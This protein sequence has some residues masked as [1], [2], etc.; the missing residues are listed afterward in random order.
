VGA[1]SSRDFGMKEGSIS[2][3]E[4]APTAF[5]DAQIKF[6]PNNKA[7]FKSLQSRSDPQR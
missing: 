3:L 1:A 4:A 2:R 5:F 6:I 7:Y